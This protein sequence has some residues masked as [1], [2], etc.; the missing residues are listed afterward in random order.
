M[1][2]FIIHASIPGFS[3][4]QDF[5]ILVIAHWAWAIL[6]SCKYV[7]VHKLPHMFNF[8]KAARLDGGWTKQSIADSK[9]M[10]FFAY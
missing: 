3:I 5:R 1:I 10:L 7:L 6:C 2:T 9:W 8:I 4:N